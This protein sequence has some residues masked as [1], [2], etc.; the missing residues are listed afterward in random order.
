MTDLKLAAPLVSVGTTAIIRTVLRNFGNAR[1]GRRAR[2]ADGRRP[3]GPRRIVRFAGRRRRARGLSAFSS[4]RPAIIWWKCRS[5]TTRW[6]STTGA[7]WSCRSEKRST[8]CWSTAISSPSP[9]RPRPT[10]WRRR[11]P[12]VRNRRGSR[13]RS[14]S[15]SSRNR[16][17]PTESWRPST[18][19][20]CATSPSS[21][22][23]R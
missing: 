12:R 4:R 5:T 14:A 18:W 10:I 16:S 13:G 2:A 21:I 6:R 1:V 22:S 9:T 3:V 15:K 17:F 19:W 7:A 20:S 11:S 8:F 23:R